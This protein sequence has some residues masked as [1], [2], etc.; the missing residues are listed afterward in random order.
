MKRC[1]HCGHGAGDDLSLDK[2]ASDYDPHAGLEGH[3]EDEELAI[4]NESLQELID[5]ME[6]S[7]PDDFPR[8]EGGMSIEIIAGKPKK[9]DDEEDYF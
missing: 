3:D 8:G 1:P 6:S 7:L 4:G 2:L 9:K 5:M